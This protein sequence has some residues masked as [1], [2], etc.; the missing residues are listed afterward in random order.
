MKQPGDGRR[1]FDPAVIRAVSLIRTGTKRTARRK[2]SRSAKTASRIIPIIFNSNNK[3]W[4]MDSLPDQFSFQ[5]ALYVKAS[6]LFID[7]RDD[8]PR[9]LC[10]ILEVLG[11]P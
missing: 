7:L 1:P 6:C 4:S 3:I 2:R 10:G 11:D 5:I 8:T 9:K